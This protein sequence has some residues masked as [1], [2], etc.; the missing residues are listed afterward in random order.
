MDKGNITRFQGQTDAGRFMDWFRRFMGGQGMDFSS[1]DNISQG[2][3]D[4][5]ADVDKKTAGLLFLKT[6]RATVDANT[7]GT[8]GSQSIWSSSASIDVFA[9]WPRAYDSQELAEVEVADIALIEV[10]I[11]CEVVSH[12][13]QHAVLE[14]GEAAERAKLAEMFKEITQVDEDRDHSTS[15]QDVPVPE[16]PKD[17]DGD[18][19]TAMGGCEWCEGKQE[20]C[21]YRD[22]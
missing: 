6:W 12:F 5:W 11:D 20:G 8:A 17:Y 1:E 9:I 4:Y 18:T 21:W 2:I 3:Q 13:V 14:N 19:N 22:K 7:M 16:R 15:A 10:L